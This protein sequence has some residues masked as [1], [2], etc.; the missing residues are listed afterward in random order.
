M[1]PTGGEDRGGRRGPSRP[2]SPESPS[3]LSFFPHPNTATPTS[4]LGLE[5]AGPRSRQALG[6]GTRG[7]PNGAGLDGAGSRSSF[8]RD[9]AGPAWGLRAVAGS[10]TACRTQQL[11]RWGPCLPTRG[12]VPR[13]PPPTCSSW[14]GV[15]RAP[16]WGFAV[17]AGTGGDSKPRPGA[18]GLQTWGT[19]G[20]VAS[21]RKA[22]V[23]GS[24]THTQDPRLGML[25]SR[26]RE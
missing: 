21:D 14:S 19:E 18:E 9:W 24:G 16:A 1:R 7:C 15:R 10:G 11:G 17:P 20:W 4:R 23:A 3:F 8:G 13:N 5:M 2:R 26:L 6:R 22:P 25:G 12:K